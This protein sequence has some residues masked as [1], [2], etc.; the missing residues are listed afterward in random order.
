MT[1]P[2]NNRCEHGFSRNWCPLC[3]PANGER[4]FLL[5][6]FILAVCAVA[7]REVA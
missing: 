2:S 6:A 3:P 7:L 4:C 1:S 5:V